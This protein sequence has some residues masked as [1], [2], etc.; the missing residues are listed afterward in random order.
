MSHIKSHSIRAKFGIL[1]RKLQAKKKVD[2]LPKPIQTRMN[3]IGVII[4]VTQMHRVRTL[5]VRMI[6]PV[7]MDTM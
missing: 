7:M 3:A 4:T 2:F 1:L 6:V 5:M